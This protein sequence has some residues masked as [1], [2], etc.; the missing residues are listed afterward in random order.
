MKLTT[1]LKKEQSI[2][3]A[4]ERVFS[5]VGFKNARMEDIAL[6]GSITKVT[7]YS[8]FQSKDNLIMGVTYQALS[9]LEESY[10]KTLKDYKDMNGLDLTMKVMETFI[11]FCEE[12]YFYSEVLLEYFAI[13]RSTSM[14]ADDDKLSEATKDSGYFSKLKALHN[15][16]FKVTANAISKGVKDGSIDKDVDPMFA[17]INGWIVIIGYVKLLS[18]SGDSATPI[19]NVNLEDIKKFNLKLLKSIMQGKIKYG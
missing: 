3:E 2:I 14:L 6:E 11:R 12:N 16:P 10:D 19:F 5:K 7:L 8:Y 4:A 18:S 9:K 13:I 1:K 15:Y 17:T